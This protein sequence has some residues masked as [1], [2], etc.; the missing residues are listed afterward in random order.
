METKLTNIFDGRF[1][2]ST[3]Y[4]LCALSLGLAGGTALVALAAG[5]VVAAAVAVG[6][7]LTAVEVLVL[8][9]FG[10]AGGLAGLCFLGAAVAG[11]L[12]G[13]PLD[14]AS[15]VEL[16]SGVTISL[17]AAIGGGA[18]LIAKAGGEGAPGRLVLESKVDDDRGRTFEGFS[19]VAVTDLKPSGLAEI[20]GRRVDVV[21]DGGAIEAGTRI[22]VVEDTGFRTLVKATDA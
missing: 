17:L 3:K 9:G 18:G 11:F 6:A 16:F 19:G 15:A 2:A 4:S 14:G 13:T 20:D 21:A 7:V 8:P 10:I 12:T 1:S 5:P 22:E